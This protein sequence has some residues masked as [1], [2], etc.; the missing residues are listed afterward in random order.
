LFLANYRW[1]FSIRKKNHYSRNR[2]KKTLVPILVALLG[3]AMPGIVRANSVPLFGTGLSLSGTTLS[4]GAADPHYTVV[5]TGS[6]AVVLSDLWGNWF[7]NDSSSAWI[8]W[9][10]N[11][12]PGNYGIHTFRITF[13]LTGYNPA[14][15]TLSGGWCADNSGLIKLN[16]NSTGVSQGDDFGIAPGLIPF[17]LSSGFTSGLN[18][19]D[20]V[21]DFPDGYD[22]LRV[23]NLALDF[24]AVPE[25]ASLSLLVL[26]VFTVII[27]RPNDNSQA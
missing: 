19:L 4:G 27:R 5:E 18:T 21:C 16:G 2:M 15:T 3:F 20:F 6:P 24:N 1:H 11:P 14:T 22:G 23:G 9:S 7:A 12:F 25:P 17:T 8:G 26:G 13:D 10:D